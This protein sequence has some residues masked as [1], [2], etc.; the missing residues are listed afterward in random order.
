MLLYKIGLSI[1]Y[2]EYVIN[3]AHKLKWFPHLLYGPHVAGD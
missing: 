1:F 3:I 2:D